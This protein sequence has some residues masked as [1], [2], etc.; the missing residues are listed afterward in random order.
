MFFE[1]LE[2]AM[3]LI[4][5]NTFLLQTNDRTKLIDL[6]TFCFL[7]H[8]DA[9]KNLYIQQ[10]FGTF[11]LRHLKPSEWMISVFYKRKKKIE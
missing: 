9:P 1:R 4:T 3:L 8:T 7:P 11:L 10:H 2:I 6:V 5:T